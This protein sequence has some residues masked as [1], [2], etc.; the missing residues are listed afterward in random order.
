MK[1]KEKQGGVDFFKVA[2]TGDLDLLEKYL[3][4]P[5]FDRNVRDQ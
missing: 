5:D 2:S 1:K 3:R 4:L